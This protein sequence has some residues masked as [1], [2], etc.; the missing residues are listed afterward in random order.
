M[1][2]GNK[3]K[4]LAVASKGGHW[5]QLLK[6]RSLW[7]G[8]GF[9][10]MYV[11]NDKSLSYYVPND[12][13]SFVIDANKESKLKLVLMS[14]QILALILLCRP[15]VVITTGAAPGFFALF[16]GKA[17]RKKTIWI[18]SIANG[19][20]MSLSGLKVKKFADVWL[21]QWPELAK[22]DGPKYLGSIF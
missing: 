12:K 3:V 5:I 22:N 21:T 9:K 2:S 14:L 20:E 11:T 17:M 15:D 10:V 4:V 8:E 19:D 7:D 16:F 1:K 13:V 18:D 6:L